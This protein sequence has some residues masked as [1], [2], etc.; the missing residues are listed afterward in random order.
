MRYTFDSREVK[1]GMGFVA[2]KGEKVDGREFIPMARERGAAEIVEGLDAL[3]RNLT[4][5]IAADDLRLD[6]GAGG[7]GRSIYVGYESNLWDVV[8]AVGRNLCHYVSVLVKGGLDAHFHQLLAEHLQEH[9]LFVGAG[10]AGRVLV[11]LSV[12]GHVS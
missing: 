7:I 2:L 10:L 4:T 1:P 9:E 6:V 3:Q 8:S 12:N 11:G 5:V